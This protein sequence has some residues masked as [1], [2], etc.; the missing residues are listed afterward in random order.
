MDKR[1]I[2][3]G[4]VLIL[5][6]LA[7][8]F[9]SS[10]YLFQ[11]PT[12]NNIGIVIAPNMTSATRFQVNQSSLVTLTYS[13]T[14]PVDAYIINSS[15]YADAV[16]FIN[17]SQKLNKYAMALEG[18]GVLAVYLNSTSGMFSNGLYASNSNIGIGKPVYS[19]DVQSY[20]N[21]TYYAIL[22]N[23]G[24]EDANVTMVETINTGIT[25]QVGSILYD[26][27]IVGL[28][29]IFGIGIIFFGVIRKSKEKAPVKEYEKVYGNEENE[30][31]KKP[32]E[33]GSNK[34][35]R[36]QMA[37]RKGKGR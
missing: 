17:N 31:V 32:I 9:F 10:S 24:N 36:K 18:K 34:K 7:A 25:Q 26:S 20:T 33:R 22:Q 3:F 4:I 5:L 37:G 19:G 8:A 28:L 21:G 27:I 29:F 6:A 35:K 2:Y 1:F 16:S 30:K 23:F 15:A 12:F 11:T 14:K 13:S